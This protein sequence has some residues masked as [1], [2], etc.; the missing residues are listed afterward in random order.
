MKVGAPPTNSTSTLTVPNLTAST[1]L[2]AID[3]A[4]RRIPPGLRFVG[5]AAPVLTGPPM[6]RRWAVTLYLERER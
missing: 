4:K 2:D 1:A 6:L 5:N 3:M